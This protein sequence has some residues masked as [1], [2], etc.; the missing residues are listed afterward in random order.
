MKATPTKDEIEA[1]KARLVRRRKLRLELLDLCDQ[2]SLN[3]NSY[4]DDQSRVTMARHRVEMCELAIRIYELEYPPTCEVPF[5]ELNTDG[6]A[7][8]D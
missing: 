5:P 7:V 3:P 8:P 6:A 4:V 1:H 2:Q